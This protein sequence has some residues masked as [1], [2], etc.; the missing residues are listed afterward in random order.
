VPEPKF[1]KPDQDKLVSSE[2]RRGRH[3]QPPLRRLPAGR[4]NDAK[5]IVGKI[6]EAARASAELRTET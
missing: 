6:I 3:R 1:F 5:I 4:P 2:V